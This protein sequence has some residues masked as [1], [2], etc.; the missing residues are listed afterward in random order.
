[1]L[2]RLKMFL[3]PTAEQYERKADYRAR[4]QMFGAFALGLLV[5]A[6]LTA[7]S[8]QYWWAV[9]SAVMSATQGAWAIRSYRSRNLR[10]RDSGDQ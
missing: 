1:M 3:N 2:R 4:V 8:G 10:P 5:L 6:V 9:I 7:A